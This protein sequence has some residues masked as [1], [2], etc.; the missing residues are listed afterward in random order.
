MHFISNLTPTERFII[1]EIKDA[2]SKMK[3]SYSNFVHLKF[4]WVHAF[5]WMNLLLTKL[6]FISFYKPLR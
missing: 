3:I 5:P 4:G 1:L 2:L 6:D